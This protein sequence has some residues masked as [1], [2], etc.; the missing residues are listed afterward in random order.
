MILHITA[1][2][3]AGNNSFHLGAYTLGWRGGEETGIIITNNIYVLKGE[4]CWRQRE[5][6]EENRGEQEVLVIW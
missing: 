3:D 2:G 4:A 1:L 6:K 5:S